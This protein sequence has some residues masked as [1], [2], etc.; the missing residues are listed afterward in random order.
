VLV[1]RPGATAIPARRW[2]WFR[3]GGEGNA[4]ALV[5]LG[6]RGQCGSV[7]LG[8]SFLVPDNAGGAIALTVADSMF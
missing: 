4:A 3:R 7:D 5:S 1:S 2:R 8:V 6:R